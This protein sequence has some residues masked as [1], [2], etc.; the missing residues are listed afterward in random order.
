MPYMIDVHFPAHI[1]C[2]V[3]RT[4]VGVYNVGMVLL[5]YRPDFLSSN[6]IVPN[7]LD[8]TWQIA[9]NILLCGIY[10]FKR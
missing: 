5:Y 1:C 7:R 4:Y 10:S 9:G 3:K 6:V 8:E 2:G